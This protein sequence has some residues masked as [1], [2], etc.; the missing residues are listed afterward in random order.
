MNERLI[1]LKDKLDNI[2]TTLTAMAFPAE[3]FSSMGGYTHPFL[4]QKDLAGLPKMLSERI[5]QMHDFIPS[6]EDIDVIDA[7]IKAL[8]NSQTNIAHV[9][10]G[11]AQVSQSALSAYLT[12]M[13]YISERINNLF[14]FEKLKDKS[15]LP[16]AITRRLELYDSNLSSI[17]VKTGDIEGKIKIIND[18]FDA[19]ENLPTT[20]K[21]LR[22]T[23]EE[24]KS[25]FERSHLDYEK[26][27]EILTLAKTN[28]T[29]IEDAKDVILKLKAETEEEARQ[30]L[31]SLKDEAQTYIDKCEEAFRTT[32]SKGLAGAFQDKA[33]KLNKS[34]RWWVGGLVVALTAGAFVGYTRLHA[35]EAYLS[36]PDSSGV[37]LTIQLILSV[38]SVGAPLWFAWLSTKQIGQ[39][40]RLAEDYEFKASVSKAYEG[41]RREAVQLDSDF[42]QR[43]FGNALTRLEEPPLRFVEET[44]HSS[45]IME[46][47][48]SENFKKLIENGGDKLDSVL[49]G[50]GLSRKRKPEAQVKKDAQEITQESDS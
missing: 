8:D 2:N 23:N 24:V 33:E 42:T 38:L 40:F 10:H 19:A 1:E 28:S 7:L 20:V 27:S 34:I 25:V 50:V 44:A 47:L 17:E 32:T 36:N 11:N 31:A 6:S 18:A 26:I 45:P 49:D 21:N 48:S 3:Y 12:S 29:S 9:N 43:L 46:M 13:L 39:R 41:Y 14:S 22:E 15:L 4:S 35:L 5:A 16:K 37:K 30:Y